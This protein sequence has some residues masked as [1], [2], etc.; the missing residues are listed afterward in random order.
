MT[1]KELN[2]IL[3][4]L[5]TEKNNKAVSSLGHGTHECFDL[6]V[7]F[8]NRLGIP[9]VS[10]NPSPFPFRDAKQIYSDFNAQQALWFDRV[11]N[12]PTAIPIKGDILVWNG[13]YNGWL[14]RGVGHTALATGEADTN[15]FVA[16]SQNDPLGTYAH[17]VRYSYKH[18]SGW[19]RPKAINS[20]QPP[21]QDR[22]P[23]RFDLINSVTFKKPHEQVT[24]AE[25]EQFVKDY[26]SQ[27]SRSDK[28]DKLCKLAGLDGDTN[29][30]TPEY[31][32]ASI[33]QEY[34]QETIISKITEAVRRALEQ[35]T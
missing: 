34:D 17:L 27:L 1:R 10:G 33:N 23:Y 25:V 15:T 5:L 3:D 6:I 32:Y 18:V 14:G 4:K 13:S 9:H 12:T 28:W 21:M 30:P 26:P 31:L 11:E 2:E 24:D 7:E 19:V 16:F 35:K 20:P 8:T 29:I 22:R